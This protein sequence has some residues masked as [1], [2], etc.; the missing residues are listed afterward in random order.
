M[1]PGSSSV[2]G[3]ASS[4]ASWK[5]DNAHAIDASAFETSTSQVVVLTNIL[6]TSRSVRVQGITKGAVARLYRSS[7]TEDMVLVGE[8]AL[9]GG[10]PRQSRG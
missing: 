3:L 6:T 1:P 5:V 7:A 10:A 9:T 4:D 2:K 8:P